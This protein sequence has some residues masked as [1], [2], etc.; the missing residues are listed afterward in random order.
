MLILEYHPTNGGAQRQLASLA[1]H[2]QERGI[3]IHVLTRQ[4]GGYP[5]RELVDGIAVHR[6]PA[7]GPK[8]SASAVFTAA[9]MV[10]LR[11]LAPDVVHAHSLFSP[12]TVAVLAHRLLGLPTVAKALRGGELGDV[13]RIGRKAFS[14]LRIAAI[15]AHIDRFAV[16]SREIEAELAAMGVAAEKRVQLP[17]GVDLERFR[18]LAAEARDALRLELGVDQ[19][20]V[21]LF[22]GR[23][24]PEKGVD[25]LLGAWRGVRKRLENAQLVVLGGGPLEP[26][27]R[28]AAGPGVRFEG[29]LA[30]VSPWLRAAD[31]FVLPSTAEGLS[32]AIL[33]AM[34]AALP[35]V[36]TRVGGAADC[37]E[38]G[39]SGVLVPPEDTPALAD[40][41]AKLLVDPNREQLGARA[42]AI[43]EQ[44]YSLESLADQLAALY[45]ELAGSSAQLDHGVHHTSGREVPA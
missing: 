7:P 10:R 28:A 3:E 41:L 31:A 11:E 38:D 16:I 39:R 32:N 43:A 29:E 33:E 45:Q 34:A 25:R 42:R 44:R 17:N 1:P 35:V 13:F 27:L 21:V 23:L 18:P 20:P 12:T 24:V 2:L 26:E 22:C 9:A 40:A 14:R 36:A 19:G 37:I 8:A 6:L 30:D 4:V 15:R 5:A